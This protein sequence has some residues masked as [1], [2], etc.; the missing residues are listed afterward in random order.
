MSTRLS[1][2]PNPNDG[3]LLHVSLSDLDG[4][5]N[6]VAVDVTDAYGKLVLNSIIPVQDGLLN[7]S[8]DL[9]QDL[10]PGLYLVNLQAGDQ[11]FTERLVIQ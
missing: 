6:T 2:W 3:S 4:S 9:Q 7:S 10:A 8:I 5:V 1:I 11:R